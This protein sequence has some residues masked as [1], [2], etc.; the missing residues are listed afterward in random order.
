MRSHFPGWIKFRIR[1]DEWVD[2]LVNGWSGVGEY[3]V[4]Q[5]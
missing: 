5:V 3:I 1:V 4:I 2:V